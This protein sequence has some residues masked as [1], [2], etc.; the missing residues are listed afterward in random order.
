MN[1]IIISGYDNTIIEFSDIY[2]EPDIS[3]IEASKHI[4]LGLMPKSRRII[5]KFLISKI[6]FNATIKCNST[7]Y[8]II[9]SYFLNVE[10]YS[11]ETAIIVIGYCE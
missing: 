8:K 6:N 1:K 11:D 4:I 2:P 9:N 3:H 10:P 7:E 5:D